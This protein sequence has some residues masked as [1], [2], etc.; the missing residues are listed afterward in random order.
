MTSLKE[1]ER[2][3]QIHL[4]K[5][6]RARQHV[7]SLAVLVLISFIVFVVSV[8]V[9]ADD[10]ARIV[11]TG[12]VVAVAIQLAFTVF[13]YSH[14]KKSRAI[15]LQIIDTDSGDEKSKEEKS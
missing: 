15:A 11:V 12:Q 8:S 9:G 6:E 10:F 13:G 14:Y 1:L 5:E 3:R 4:T 2:K 7:L